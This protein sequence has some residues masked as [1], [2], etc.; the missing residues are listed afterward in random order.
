[1]TFLQPVYG[2]AQ[3]DQG[4]KNV[5]VVSRGSEAKRND[6]GERNP[7]PPTGGEAYTV[8]LGAVLL[9]YAFFYLAFVIIAF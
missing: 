1:M 3:Q 8:L 5:G 9:F 2:L 4:C 7:E 6:L